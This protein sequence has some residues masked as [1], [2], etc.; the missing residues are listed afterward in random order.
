MIMKRAIGFLFLL[1]LAACSSASS[2]ETTLAPSRDQPAV[3]TTTKPQD[4]PTP[5]SVTTTT[6]AD[7]VQQPLGG[8]LGVDRFAI[9][10]G[11]EVAAGSEVAVHDAS[12][13]LVFRSRFADVAQADE[14]HARLNEEFGGLLQS[15][16]DGDEVCVVDGFDVSSHWVLCTTTGA[17]D[18][19]VIKQVSSADDIRIVGSLPLPPA[20]IEGA[21]RIGVWSE[22]FVRPDGVILAQLKT[23]CETRYAMMIRD[24]NATFLNGEGYWGEWPT[25][26]S[27]AL[28]WDEQG[29]AL[30]W[31][32]S[33]PCSEEDIVPGVYAY[34]DDFSRELVMETTG[35][36]RGIRTDQLTRSTAS[37]Y[38]YRSDA[39]LSTVL[40]SDGPLLDDFELAVDY[41]TW[42]LG[43]DEVVSDDGLDGTDSWVYYFS[44]GERNVAVRMEAAGWQLDGDMVPVITSATT[45]EFYDHA[46]LGIS[47]SP[48]D[49]TWVADIWVPES[50]QLGFDADV[51]ATVRLSYESAVY[52]GVLEEGRIRFALSG[53]PHVFGV[54]EFEYR[55]A[56]GDIVGWHSETIPAGSYSAG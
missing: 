28:G 21:T 52:E 44:S 19:P 7:L 46:F 33:G 24:G 27:V 20:E 10:A 3:T 9:L 43:W 55:D 45:L 36:V 49:G 6:V 25:G 51:T 56:D 42:V 32:F 39:Q 23:E 54:I 30:V 29:R 2:V 34:G 16:T 41:L 26:E 40:V 13:S 17:D 14:R 53:D 4:L 48:V 47:V 37:V 38:P 15:A 5:T 11:F 31:H 35:E 50:G 12:G 22:I 18:N 8:Y 1:A